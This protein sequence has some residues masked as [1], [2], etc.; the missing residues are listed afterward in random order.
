MNGEEW[1]G[2]DLIRFEL[3]VAANVPKIVKDAME[4]LAK[5]H[6]AYFTGG[7]A[8]SHLATMPPCQQLQV[9]RRPECRIVRKTAAKRPA[10]AVRKI[11]AKRPARR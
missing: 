4:K 3:D 6:G 10:G 9:L 1:K 7:T 5:D 11:A 2:S 8:A